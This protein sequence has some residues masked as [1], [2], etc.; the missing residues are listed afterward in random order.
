MDILIV[1][2]TPLYRD[3]L[4]QHLACYRDLNFHLAATRHEALA[5]AATRNFHFFVLAG[6]LPD[7]DGIELG[8]ALRQA[9]QQA[10]VVLLTGTPS[11]ALADRAARMGITELFRRQDVEELLSF[12][13]H[14]LEAHQPL[15]CRVLYV[16]DAREQRELLAEQ[17]RE[18][19]MVVDAFDSADAAWPS[20]LETDYELVLC[21]VMLGG[22]MSG[23]RLINRIRRLSLPKGATPVLAVTAFDDPRRR[24][25]LFHLGIDD[26]VPKPI[27]PPE[28]RARLH[29]LLARQRSDMRN[30]QLLSATALGVLVIDGHGNLQSFD[31][32][33]RQLFGIGELAMA[34]CTVGRFLPALV[35]QGD[36]ALLAGGGRIEHVPMTAIRTDGLR[37]PV[38]VSSMALDP[39]DGQLQ[40][41]LLV[42]DVS[43]ERALTEHL[44]AARDSAEQAGRSK[45]AFLASMS[46][47]IRTPLNAIIGLT[48]LMRRDGLPPAQAERAERIDAAGKLLLG[49]INDVLDLSRIEAGRLTL[50]SLPLTPGAIVANVAAMLKGK[51]AGK[52]LALFVD[53]AA[54]ADEV[55]LGD[56]TRLTQALINYVAN[57]I[58]FTDSGSVTIALERLADDAAAVTLRFS[59][60]D[61]GIGLADADCERVFDDF[62]QADTSTARRYGGSGLGL[63]ITRRLV[64]LMGGESGVE[65]CLGEGSRF[66]FTVRLSRAPAPAADVPEVLAA[67]RQLRERHAGR[68]VLLVE[69]DEINREV[70]GELL[71]DAL[72]TVRCAVDGLAALAEI[73][74]EPPA[75]V[76]MDMQ[77]PRMDGLE[78]AG[79]IREL[80]GDM[81]IVA[82]TAN[83]FAEDRERCLHAGMDDFIA[84]PVVPERLY[85]TVL[86]WLDRS[87]GWSV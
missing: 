55:L 66:W 27:S 43:R 65:S 79:R 58:K 11:A 10:P 85:E 20:F 15:R 37:C 40:F 23:S 1:D 84:K 61:T 9:G 50:E 82:M 24:V 67:E 73:D 68:C 62:Q 80:G 41:A 83:A 31:A 6:Q 71:R 77:M 76:L 42:R 56:A 17:L 38:E 30:R 59:V 72:L 63:A 52:G 44:A 21:D 33:A 53:V 51:A 36:L 4:Q 87:A 35:D 2:G 19:G 13:R 25:E 46:H 49:V 39:V 78:A 47:E 7:G 74:R 34:G 12:M 32:N 28:L 3:I 5:Q 70:A 18:W 16:E 54:G 81:P 26:Y 45:S 48:Y 29:N 64:G 22:R 8:C 14:F 60:S 57:A 69:D 75:L 86:L